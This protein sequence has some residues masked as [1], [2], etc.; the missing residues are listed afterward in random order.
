MQNYLV[1]RLVLDR[2]SSLSQ[3]F[4]DARVHYRK[5]SASFIHLKMLSITCGP[6]M[7]ITGVW[8]KNLINKAPVLLGQS[9]V[10]SQQRRS[11]GCQKPSVTTGGTGHGRELLDRGHFGFQDIKRLGQALGSVQADH[12][13]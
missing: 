10:R 8:D 4:K 6:C 13:V 9:T 11:L 5:V 12:Q 2:I 7:V 3:R 1:W